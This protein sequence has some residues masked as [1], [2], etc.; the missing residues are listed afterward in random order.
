MDSRSPRCDYD[1]LVWAC[2]E[3]FFYRIEAASSRMSNGIPSQSYQVERESFHFSFGR[4]SSMTNDRVGWFRCM[5]GGTKERQVY[6]KKKLNYRC[7]R[8]KGGNKSF[9]AFYTSICATSWKMLF[10]LS[11]E[12]NR[13]WLIGKFRADAI[14]FTLLSLLIGFFF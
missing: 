9:E 8:Q 11:R 5:L 1:A 14:R 3:V 7:P 4:H 6:W 12:Y 2:I 13:N 10:S